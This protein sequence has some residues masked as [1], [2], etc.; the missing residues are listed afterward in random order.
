M[1]GTPRVVAEISL[2]HFRPSRK[3]IAMSGTWMTDAELKDILLTLAK[4]GAP[5]PKKGTALGDALVRFTTA[6]GDAG[7]L[8]DGFKPGQIE[9]P[10]LKTFVVTLNVSKTLDMDFEVEAESAEEASNLAENYGVD[11]D[12]AEGDT[13]YL[14]THVGVRKFHFA[15]S[16]WPDYDISTIQTEEIPADEQEDVVAVE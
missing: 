1:V 14:M 15:D 7:L 6:A 4:S 3:E 2:G 11:E 12:M 9:K 16:G 10:P 5:K 13:R 8:S